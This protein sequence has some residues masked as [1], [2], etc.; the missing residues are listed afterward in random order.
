MKQWYVKDLS[1]LTGVSVQTLH[2]YDR[3]DL[4]NPS[5]RTESGYRVYSENDL[6]KLQQILA[7]K[8]F[9][10]ELAQI[11]ILLAA[12]V[13][14]LEHFSVQ[15]KFLDEKAQALQSASKVLSG[16]IS[17]LQDDKSITWETILNL[18]EVYR[19]T[20]D[21]EKSWAGQALT[22][23]ELKQ[24]A[25]FQQKLSVKF[26]QKHGSRD[27]FRNKRATLIEQIMENLTD[28]SSDVS[29]QIAE[30][31]MNLINSMYDPEDADLKQAIWDKGFRQGKVDDESALDPKVVQW[32]ESAIKHYYYTRIDAL[33]SEIAEPNQAYPEVLVQWQALVLEKCGHSVTLKQSLFDAVMAHDQTSDEAKK[34][35]KTYWKF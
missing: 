3:V 14:A 19:M 18:I 2:H 30:A 6:L 29:Y 9:G 33:L 5:F 10:F 8:Y 27:D 23:D 12:D 13:S 7:L 34:W 35:L 25:Q 22:A 4:L 32:L 1:K 15:A 20:Q 26:E 31:F 24:Y 28:P 21:L 11:K 17:E 16:I